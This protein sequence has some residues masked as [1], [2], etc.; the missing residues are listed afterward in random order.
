VFLM[1]AVLDKVKTDAEQIVSEWLGTDYLNEDDVF[2]IGCSTSEVIG[3]HIGTAGSEEVAEVLY[4][5]LQKLREEKGVH[6]VFQGCEHINRGLIMEE[7]TRKMLGL[8]PVTVVPHPKA[9]GSMASYV[10][11]QMQAPTVVE[12]V[13]ADAGLDIGDTL[14]GMHLKPVA[15]PL[16]FDRTSIGNA[17]VTGARTRPKLIGGERAIYK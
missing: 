13:T 9:G 14:I 12:N 15:V 7:R 11:K 2:V 4:T 17:H 16:R 1:T 10:Y 8:P 6:L 5:A 3:E